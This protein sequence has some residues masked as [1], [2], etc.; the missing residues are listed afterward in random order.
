[1]QALRPHFLCRF[2]TGNTPADRQMPIASVVSR[3]Y[4]KEKQRR[5]K[6]ETEAQQTKKTS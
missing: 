4:K 1:L 5:D 2:A 6:A 3:Y